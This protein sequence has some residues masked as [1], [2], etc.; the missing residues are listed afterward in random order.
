MWK[1][2]IYIPVDS[3]IKE[4]QI[5]FELYKDWIIKLFHAEHQTAE[6]MAQLL[7]KL[8][9]N[10]KKTVSQFKYRHPSGGGM[11]EATS[12]AVILICATPTD[13]D[14]LLFFGISYEPIEEPAPQ[15]NPEILVI[16]VLME[17]YLIK[18]NNPTVFSL[19]S[20]A[21]RAWMRQ[22]NWAYYLKKNL[23]SFFCN[24][25]QQKAIFWSGYEACHGIGWGKTANSKSSRC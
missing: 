18:E 5:S 20:W 24:V 14:L 13:G 25:F 8:E 7:N 15:R 9:Q 19:E 1:L 10:A 21:L 16:H 4:S 3:D 11:W 22:P 12:V 2:N 23:S 6:T 17:N